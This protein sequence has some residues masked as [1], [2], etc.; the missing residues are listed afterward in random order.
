[1]RRTVAALRANGGGNVETAVKVAL[2]AANA[3]HD[4]DRNQFLLYFGLIISALS[5]AGRKAF[6]MQP[7]GIQ[8]FDESQRQSFNRGRSS[9]VI[10]VLE[11]R[12][13]PVSDSQRNSIEACTDLDILD[14][15]IRRA[16]VVSTVEELFE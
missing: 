9:S 7:Q 15:W 10:A 5:D 8:F 2:A 13:V 4:L 6:K 14:R 11:A 1:L 16:A 12:G 3:A